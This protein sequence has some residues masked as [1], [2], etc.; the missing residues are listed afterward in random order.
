MWRLGVRLTS[1][2]GNRLLIVGHQDSGTG[3]LRQCSGSELN[4]VCVGTTR[5]PSCP[6]TFSS[7]CTMAWT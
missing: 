2:P 1:Y 7:A 4:G 3:G 5:V 6:R